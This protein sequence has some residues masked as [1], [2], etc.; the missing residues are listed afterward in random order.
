[1]S[2]IQFPTILLGPGNFNA[3][4]RDNNGN[5][6][7][8]MEA[9]LPFTIEARW[10]IDALSALLLGG[11]WEVTAY[12]ESIGPGPERSLG[13]V[14]VPLD[15]GRNYSAVITVPANTL[16]DNP[17]APNSGVYKLVTVLT[18]RNFTKITNLSGISE[19]P[20]VRIG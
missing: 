15:G 11:Q 6:S 4:L 18:H 12:V 5:P 1:M 19:G 3:R 10:N 14:T 17:P 8:V 20:I 13:T 2:G 7:E 9:S 16:P